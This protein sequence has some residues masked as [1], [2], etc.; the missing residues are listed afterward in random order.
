MYSVYC[1]L[2]VYCIIMYNVYT[3]DQIRVYHGQITV[4]L[5]ILRVAQ[6]LPQKTIIHQIIT[7]NDLKSVLGLKT[8]EYQ[9]IELVRTLFC[10]MFSASKIGIVVEGPKSKSS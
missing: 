7:L 3:R 8:I 6:Y 5:I 9:L 4:Q 2:T 10:D 1:I